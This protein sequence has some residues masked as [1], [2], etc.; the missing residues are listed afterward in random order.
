[1]AMI[2]MTPNIWTEIQLGLWEGTLECVEACGSW[3]K[4]EDKHRFIEVVSQAY[5]ENV[6]NATKFLSLIRRAVSI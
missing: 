5:E 2:K 3:S 4:E 6:I 1:M